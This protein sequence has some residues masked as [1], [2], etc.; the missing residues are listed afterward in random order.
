MYYLVPT[1]QIAEKIIEFVS[2]S[3]PKFISIIYKNIG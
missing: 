1:T 3:M 2:E